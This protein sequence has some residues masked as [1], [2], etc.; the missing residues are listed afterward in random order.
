MSPRQRHGDFHEAHHYIPPMEKFDV[1]TTTHATFVPKTGEMRPSLKPKDHR[2][3]GEGT[4]DFNTVN[5]VEYKKPN[6]AG[7]L[8]RS[9]AKFLLKE[10]RQRHDR[11]SKALELQTSKQGGQAVC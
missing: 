3:G 7:R 5:M 1:T 4:H 10:L 9:N 2:V 8:N 6:M 11:E